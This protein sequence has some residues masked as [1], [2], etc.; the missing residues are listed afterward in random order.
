MTRRQTTTSAFPNLPPTRQ[1][2]ADFADLARRVALR[3][4]DVRHFIV[5]NEFK[6][7]WDPTRSNWDYV[8]Y[9]DLYNQVYRALKSVSRATRVGGPYLVIDGTGS[10]GLGRAGPVEPAAADPITPQNNAVLDYW[11]AHKAGADFIAIDRKLQS[12]HDPT[13]YSSDEYLRLTAWHGRIAQQLRARTSLP[14]WYVEDYF[15]DDPDWRFQA[16]GL[17]SMLVSEVIGGVSTSLRWGP[18]GSSGSADGG[19]TQN[20]FSDTRAPGGGRPFPAFFVY[21]AFARHFGPGTRLVRAR[22][23]S[24]KVEALASPRVT[25][26]INRTPESLVVG[27]DGRDVALRPYGVRAVRAP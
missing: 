23:N 25:L 24:A 9:T 21:A 27:L 7:F 6:G 17:A 15:R 20:L 13:V 26:L 12:H 16:A 11:L 18:Q 5:W 8:A 2:F 1:H 14:I 22:T 10:A 4:P 19:N 3:Y